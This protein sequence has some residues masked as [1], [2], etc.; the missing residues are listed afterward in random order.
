MQVDTLTV[1]HDRDNNNLTRY[2]RL[3]V[4]LG[5]A[6]PPRTPPVESNATIVQLVEPPT[7]SDVPVWTLSVRA[8]DAT[9]LDLCW[10]ASDTVRIMASA[11][12]PLVYFRGARCR[13]EAGAVVGVV[14]VTPHPI[15]S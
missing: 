13:L 2:Q 5:D 3:R 6:T 10:S 9:E 8:D 4:P 14:P 7:W 1:Q 12:A 15:A 11:K